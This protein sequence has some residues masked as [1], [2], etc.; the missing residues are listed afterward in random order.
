M[1]QEPDVIRRQIE[2]TRSDLTE[3]LE[4][5]ES[6]V[7]GTVK[8]AKT[9][10][11]ETID[12]VRSTV[13]ETVDGVKRTFD[14][15]YQTRQHP[16]AMFGGSVAVGFLA[17]TYLHRLRQAPVSQV[18]SGPLGN[19]YRS[20]TVA[21]Q[22]APEPPFPP[23]PTPAESKPGFLSKLWH[24]FDPE[25][26][27]VKQVAIGAAVGWLRDLAKESFPQLAPHIDEVMNS[28]SAKLG[29]KPIHESMREPGESFSWQRGTARG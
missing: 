1:D 27:N 18:Y 3:K 23:A 20:Q 16:W 17:G 14:I 28:A 25:I 11:E 4:T 19:G 5:L 22:P 6:Q 15:K 12:T 13:R 10:V 24:Q 29:G 7:R 26:E 2:R 21:S 8:N 9:S